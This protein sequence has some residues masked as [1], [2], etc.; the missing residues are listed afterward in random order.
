M[1]VLTAIMSYPKA[2][3]NGM[4]QAMRDTWL[5]NLPDW[6]DYKFFIPGKV[7]QGIP[8]AI[9]TGAEDDYWAYYDNFKHA[10]RYALSNEYDYMFHCDRDT[11]VR[12]ERLLDCRFSHYDYLGYPL[13]VPEWDGIYASMGAG[14]FFSRK[15]LEV[16][17][18]DGQHHAYSDV[19]AG[20][21]LAKAGIKLWHDPR[22][23]I[24]RI[25]VNRRSGLISM[26]LSTGT[27]AYEKEWMHEIHEEFNA[28]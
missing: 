10:C 19:A 18:D 7:N 16:I 12:P 11:Y 21:A 22:F 2:E 27:F 25:P 24:F 6:C 8:D 9:W 13:I 15:S 5:P 3:E 28:P 14:C 26:H 4:N 20:K 1:K 17:L 23:F